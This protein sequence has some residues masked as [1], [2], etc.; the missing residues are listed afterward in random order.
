[1]KQSIT[2]S[3]KDLL[4]KVSL[5]FCSS[6]YIPFWDAPIYHSSTLQSTLTK[7][8]KP[9]LG[10]KIILRIVLV[11]I[12][13]SLPLFLDLPHICN[14]SLKQFKVH[15]LISFESRVVMRA[16]DFRSSRKES[17]ISM[18][19]LSQDSCNEHNNNWLP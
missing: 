16:S 10:L 3:S 2:S 8:F 13:I 19:R 11:T 1:M 18:I 12:I 5:L 15:L 4:M 14:A 9:S 7:C 6:S 17:P